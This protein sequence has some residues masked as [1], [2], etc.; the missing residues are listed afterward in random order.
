LP[1]VD[2]ASAF[3][4]GVV[5]ISPLFFS[6]SRFSTTVGYESGSLLTVK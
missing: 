3:V 4:A 2:Y 1:V 6:R 5:L